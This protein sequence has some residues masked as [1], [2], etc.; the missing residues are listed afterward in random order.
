MASIRKRSGAWQV[1]WRARDGIMRSWTCSTAAAA[2]AVA[3]DIERALDFGRDWEPPQARSRPRVVEV[4]AAYQDARR[5]RCRPATLKNE[6]AQFDVALRFLDERGVRHL[7]EL[8]RPLLDDL[9]AW[10]LRPDTA[11]HGQQRRPQSASRIVGALLGLWRWAEDSGRYQDVPRAPHHV[12]LP[13]HAPAPVVAPTWA[14]MDAMIGACTGWLRRLAVWLRWTG[15]RSG[16]S[17]LVEWR[18]VDVD[19]GTLTIRPEIDKQGQGRVVPL[20]PGLLD[21]IATWGRREGYVIPCTRAAGEREREARSRDA[22][23]AW[24]RA[25]VR[26]AAWRAHPWHAFRRGFKSGLL[27]LGAHPDAVDFL[28]GHSLGSGSR[29]RYIDGALLP[30][31]ETVATVPVVGRVVSISC[32]QGVAKKP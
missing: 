18:D 2:Q 28:Q 32:G 13:R 17:M 10:L 16:E 31:R 9:L 26:E 8:A 11:R 24:Q 1:R 15:L 22:A 7:D 14:E 6:G 29:G 19:R 25:G 20:A 27:Q 21:E 3:R 30:L 12:D 4:A 5:L 23:R